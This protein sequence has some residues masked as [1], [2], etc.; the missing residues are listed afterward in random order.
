MATEKQLG[1]NLKVGKNTAI[2]WI[3]LM[4]QFISEMKD[5][6]LFYF[7]SPKWINLYKTYISM[8]TSS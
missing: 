6:A 7:F 4:N 3:P 1:N 2:F 5:F 8:M